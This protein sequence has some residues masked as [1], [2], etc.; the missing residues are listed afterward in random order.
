VTHL[1]RWVTEIAMND[2]MQDILEWGIAHDALEQASQLC[3]R[4]WAKPRSLGSCDFLLD[5]F[6]REESERGPIILW[7]QGRPANK[8]EEA[9]PP[10]SITFTIRHREQC[11]I[12]YTETCS[13]VWK[14]GAWITGPKS[15]LF[16]TSGGLL[17][18]P[19]VLD[20]KVGFERW[21]KGLPQP[22]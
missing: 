4:L 3:Y 17:S 7:K 6:F 2:A 8:I 18:K 11:G 19:V 20:S 10:G 15:E 16:M 22:F 12:H 21:V 1:Q 9:L 5:V 14:D 13:C